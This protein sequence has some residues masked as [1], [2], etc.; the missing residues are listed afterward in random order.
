MNWTL[1]SLQTA[2]A[3][4]WRNRGGRTR[5]LLAWPEPGRWRVRISV[6]Y[7]AEMKAPSTSDAARVFALSPANW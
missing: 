6:K 5:E 7:G 2:A 3:Q 1:V 4:P